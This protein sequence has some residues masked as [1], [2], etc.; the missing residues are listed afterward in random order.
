[1][2]LKTILRTAMVIAM[3]VRSLQALPWTGAT[4]VFPENVTPTPATGSVITNAN[5][6]ILKAGGL[7]A[8]DRVDPETSLTTGDTSF[9]RFED[10][11]GDF[12]KKIRLVS[13]APEQVDPNVPPPEGADA[14]TR[15]GLILRSG[16]I[17]NT[18]TLEIA[19][20][21]PLSATGNFVRV[22]GRGLS[23]QI[24]AQVLSRNYPGVTETLPNQWL[25]VRRVGN[26][27]SF[28][29]G[30]NG[31]DWSLIADQYQVFPAT[32]QFGAFASPDNAEGTS[33]AVAEFA[34][35][36]DVEVVDAVAPTLVSTGT[37]D[38]QT[39]GLKFS[40]PIASAG[41][42]VAANYTVSGATVVSAQTGV[43]P[44][45]VYLK[46][47]GLTSDTFTVTV[48][49]GLVDVTGNPVAPGSTA[50]GKKSS[51]SVTDV[52]YIQNPNS[53]P[54]PGDDPYRVGQAVAVSSDTNPEIEIVGG[55]SNAYN[56]G[57][58]IT[59]VYREYPSDFDVVVAVNRFDK[60]GIAG[61][62]ANGG[63]HVR[64]GLYLPN[65][66][67]VAENT[68]VPA[69]V[70]VVYYEASG[71]NRAAIQLNRP[72]PGDNYG[73][74]T[75]NLNTEEIDGLLGWFTGLRTIDAAGN[76]SEQSSPTQ[77]HWLR[78]VRSGTQFTALFSYDG[79]TWVTQDQAELDLPNLTGTVLVGFAHQNDTG[80]GVPP[81]DTYAGNG[82][83]NEEGKNTQ[84]ESNYGVVR[85]SHF[86]DFATAFPVPQLNIQTSGANVVITWIGTG[87]ALQSAG[88]LGGPYT[89][90]GLPVEVINGVNTVT[91]TP[92]NTP[93]FYRLVQ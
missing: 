35:Y 81:D 37:L 93:T 71:P 31:V 28:Y 62:Y 78:V 66:D 11:I 39:I 49:G 20:F 43:S 56:P 26:A 33:Y 85:I 10:L 75:P 79:L 57:D 15:A 80:Y 16:A 67:V 76:L 92:G 59:Y 6:F 23:N 14:L 89:P 34:D 17:A 52:G 44:N 88:T 30:T 42:S 53:R 5:S 24:Y 74:N 27:F 38:N 82:T 51:W 36:G 63:I 48:V 18:P 72:N 91:V 68:K 29:V 32:V 19:A 77:A 58:F 41:A 25:R 12:D 22:A 54:T 47:T 50:A 8:F 13:L 87:Y 64:Q 60:R 1:M 73:N 45:T 3:A 7:A 86:G 61:G 70:N 46:V 4:D 21:N 65:N 9:F 40:E 90:A 69:Y 55:G 2:K 83:L 84:N